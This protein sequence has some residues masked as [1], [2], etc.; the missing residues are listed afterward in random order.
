MSILQ[1]NEVGQP[2]D[3]EDDAE[4]MENPQ[5]GP[6]QP[7]DLQVLHGVNY[8]KHLAIAGAEQAMIL[9]ALDSLVAAASAARDKKLDMFQ[10][11]RAQALRHRNDLDICQLC[12][13]VLEDR[14]Y[15]KIGE[16]VAKNMKDFAGRRKEEGGG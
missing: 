15:S 2:Q 11:L 10:H 16:A 3:G 7:P 12:L 8:V 5:Q 14:Q 9:A 4:E 13:D 6:A 1:A